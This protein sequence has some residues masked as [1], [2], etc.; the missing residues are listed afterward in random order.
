MTC[1]SCLAALQLANHADYRDGCV[2]CGIRKLFHMEA[3]ARAAMLDRIQFAHGWG[4]RVEA[5]K[6]L[7]IE[8]ARIKALRRKATA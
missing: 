8:A 6:L 4:A 3:P 7:E 2:G 1:T 5:V